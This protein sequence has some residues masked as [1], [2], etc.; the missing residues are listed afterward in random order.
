METP[1]E[2]SKGQQ[3]LAGNTEQKEL[4]QI[5]CMDLLPAYM[6]LHHMPV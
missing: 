5:M 2:I 3:L 6:T 1:T 4:E